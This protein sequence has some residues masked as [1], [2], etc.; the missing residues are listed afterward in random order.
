MAQKK[1]ILH[2]NAEL[3]DKEILD[4]FRQI[5]KGKTTMWRI[6][7]DPTIPIGYQ[8]LWKIKNGERREILKPK[9]DKILG[10]A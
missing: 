7:K 8:A 3:D 2:T 10:N 5:A 1:G 6:H 4:L 9:I